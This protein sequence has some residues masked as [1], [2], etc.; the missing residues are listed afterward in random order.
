M[1]KLA[2][3]A[4]LA[5]PA[6]ASAQ[7]L[8]RTMALDAGPDS[9]GAVAVACCDVN[10]DGRADLILAGADGVSWR[11]SATDGSFGLSVA[12]SA[13]GA[14][15]RLGGTCDLPGCPLFA[16]IDGDGR[17]DLVALAP[18][19][20]QPI[21]GEGRVLF[22]LATPAVRWFR[23]GE[24][25]GTGAGFVSG[26][27][28][29][30][31]AG[32]LWRVPEGATSLALADWNGDGTIDVLVALRGRVQLH[33]G[34]AGRIATAA[35]PLGAAAHD[36]AV[37]DWDGDGD[38]D[39]LTGDGATSVWWCEN[40]GGRTAPELASPA[41][42]V[43]VDSDS[44]AFA[45]CPTAAGQAIVS[46]TRRDREQ[47]PPIGLTPEEAIELELAEALESQLAAKLRKLGELRPSDFTSTSMRARKELRVE[48]ESWLARPRQI[49]RELARKRA[50]RPAP[51]HLALHQR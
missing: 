37:C 23:A 25:F 18:V 28:L 38:L 35:V 33:A 22:H 47:R 42:L 4:P 19:D 10:G 46:L 29:R 16:D 51:A 30:A 1:R 20:T 39:L 50:P 41:A 9:T 36:V 6:L 32:D 15:L 14:P 40:T 31:P 43:R 12:L 26:G 7:A 49:A 34:Q 45:T 27:W 3:L 5:W 21:E 13:D 48:M 44:L 24:R 11:P 17:D 8:T 2:A